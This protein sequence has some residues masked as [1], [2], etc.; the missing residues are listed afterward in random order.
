MARFIALLSIFGLMTFGFAT[1]DTATVQAQEKKQASPE[2]QVEPESL[3]QK[4]SYLIGFQYIQNLKLEGIEI[5]L[6]ELI[7]GI[8]DSA[9]GKKP[10]MSEEEIQSVQL[11][12]QRQLVRQQQE[13]L[14]KLADENKRQGAEFLKA[15]ALKEGVKEMENGL[16]YIELKAGEGEPPGVSDSVKVHYR[17][18]Y[19]DGTMFES[20]A[21]R[22]P[23]SLTVGVGMRG[24][25]NA[26]QKMKPGAKWKLFIPSDQ[27]FG[28]Q[29]NQLVGPNQVVVYELELVEIIK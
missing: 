24:I 8:R 1:L 27:A 4:A 6:E 29:G 19:I 23:I 20:T 16:Q 3:K 15:N 14:A 10:P 25:T 28:V 18:M 11:A 13:R 22:E 21:G 26:L 9:T 2:K 7:K 12:F 17:A 5:D